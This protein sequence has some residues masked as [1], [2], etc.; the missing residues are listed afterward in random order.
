MWIPSHFKCDL[1][2]NIFELNCSHLLNKPGR[3]WGRENNPSRATF[4]AGSHSSLEICWSRVRVSWSASAPRVF[5]WSH[6]DKWIKH[7]NKFV[8]VAVTPICI[9]KFP[10]KTTSR[11]VIIHLCCCFLGGILRVL[12][13]LTP[14]KEGLPENHPGDQHAQGGA[15]PHS[16]HHVQWLR[17][18]GTEI[19]I[20]GGTSLLPGLKEP[21]EPSLQ[22]SNLVT[23]LRHLIKNK[24]REKREKKGEKKE[25]LVTCTVWN[26]TAMGYYF[27]FPLPAYFVVSLV[28]PQPLCAPSAIPRMDLESHDQ[29]PHTETWP[30]PCCHRAEPTSSKLLLP[31]LLLLARKR[32]FVPKEIKIK[33][34][35]L[36]IPRWNPC[37][38][39]SKAPQGFCC[40]PRGLDQL[41]LGDANSRIFWVC[42]IPRF[43][44]CWLKVT[45]GISLPVS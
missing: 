18:S 37:H 22:M 26:W 28:L 32:L 24:K 4:S 6:E 42:L 43:P 34:K 29:Q 36:E 39:G 44:K 5:Q 17:R 2:T 27:F 23:S 38:A 20:R 11:V 40:L 15:G 30:C 8:W 41:Q 10:G 3:S 7:A 21:P 35:K 25:F 12:L 31:P 16:R 19:W 33:W 13:S 14:G 45:L 9:Q 1:F